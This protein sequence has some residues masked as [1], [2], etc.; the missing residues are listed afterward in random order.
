MTP[1]DPSRT[2]AGQSLPPLSNRVILVA[3]VV[4]SLTIAAIVLDRRSE[5]TGELLVQSD[6]SDARV[7]IK[8]EGRVVVP[9]SDKRS[10]ILL[11]GAYDVDAISGTTPLRV[12]PP[13]VD[14]PRSGRVV[15]RIERQP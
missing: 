13:R 9:G 12:V 2:V 10:F 3:A 8:Q 7:T 14:V 1:P 15:A 4:L 6:E 11:P 5:R